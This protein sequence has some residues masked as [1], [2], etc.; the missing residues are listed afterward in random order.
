MWEEIKVT[1]SKIHILFTFDAITDNTLLEYS[2]II[3]Q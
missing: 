3:Q 2:I 1:S